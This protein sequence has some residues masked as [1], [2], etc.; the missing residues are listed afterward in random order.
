MIILLDSYRNVNAHR[1]YPFT[2]ASTLVTTDG[3]T[4]V[5][6]FIVDAYLYPIA[7]AKL[8]LNTIDTTTN[9]ITLA[10]SS[11]VVG[12]GII[13]PD[14]D[15]VSIYET[16][17]T[18]RIGRIVLGAGVTEVMSGPTYTFDRTA[19][20]VATACAGARPT[21]LEGI[22]V[23]GITLSGDV[24]IQGLDGVLVTSDGQ[25][26]RFDMTGNK[27]V[28]EGD[29]EATTTDCVVNPYTG[30]KAIPIRTIRIVQEANSI[31]VLTQTGDHGFEITANNVSL[32]DICAAQKKTPDD[33]PD[34]CDSLPPLA[35]L[36]SLPLPSTSATF[37]L[38]PDNGRIWFGA[39][40]TDNIFGVDAITGIDT[41]KIK[42]IPTQPIPID[43]YS[44]R[45]PL[46]DTLTVQ[47]I[48]LYIKG[49][50]AYERPV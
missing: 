1:K 47:S 43:Y 12:S 17:G 11:G 50:K 39:P 14:S 29:D 8:Y 7:A 35:P 28:N 31:F 10:T 44:N 5:D 16:G 6:T 37:D 46:K 20:F 25:T 13:D 21:G 33:D 32:I 4:L 22:K 24:Y 42:P 18:R 3:R 40:G 15:Q 2:D 23:N 36:I 45:S 34:A 38:V 48:R 30:E 41:L 49:L 19:E 27:E 26:V 9:E